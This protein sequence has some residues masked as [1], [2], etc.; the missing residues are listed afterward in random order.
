VMIVHFKKYHIYLFFEL[1]LIHNL[2]N[3][4]YLVPLLHSWKVDGAPFELVYVVLALLNERLEH[5]HFNLVI[6][7]EL[8]FEATEHPETV[9][10]LLN[11]SV[12][13]FYFYS[14]EINIKNT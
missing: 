14:I 4:G 8:Q 7:I 11:K 3:S 13:I 9:F 1:I 6:F 5:I 10:E 12:F 2:D